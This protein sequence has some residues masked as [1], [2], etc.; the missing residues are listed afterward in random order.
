MKEYQDSAIQYVVRAWCANEDYWTVYFDL[1][2]AIK[3][4]FDG[5]GIEMTYPH[6]NVH[7]VES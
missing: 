3:P 5:A 2:D 6:V 1:M 4:A 7:M